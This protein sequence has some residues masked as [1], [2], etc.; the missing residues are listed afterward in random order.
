MKRWLIV[1]GVLAI[2]LIAA[3]QLR[4]QDCTGQSC[5]YLPNA[6]VGNAP[7]LT[8]I[9]LDAPPIMGATPAG[10]NGCELGAPVPIEGAQAWFYYA[11][12][13]GP[14]TPTSLL[15]VR[16]VVDGRFVTGFTAQIVIHGAT[17]DGMLAA[18]GGTSGVG[19]V[20][21]QDTSADYVIGQATQVDVAVPYLDRTYVTHLS[22]VPLPGTPTATL[23]STPTQ[24]PT[25]TPTNT[26]TPTRSATPTS[27]NTPT[28]A[29]PSATPTP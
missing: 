4:A 1:A 26:V 8:P 3:E 19:G 10:T 14:A 24:T 23:T 25:N 11:Y 12:L 29:P 15:C 28:I 27:T 13:N 6:R 21:L 2:V 18:Y 17:R 5:V 20:N 7:T 16:L 22:F 9:P